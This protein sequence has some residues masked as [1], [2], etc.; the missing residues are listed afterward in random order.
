MATMESALTLSLTVFSSHR[1]SNTL[2]SSPKPPNSVKLH[3]PSL[4]YTNLIFPSSSKPSPFS[5]STTAL[6]FK[7]CS[8]L[9]EAPSTTETEENKTE[10]S[11]TQSTN[12]KTKLYVYNLPWSLSSSDIKD[13]FA[14]CGTVTDVEII[15]SP[16]GK[17]R[18][19]CFV[20]MA[21][22]DEAMDAV[23][24]FHSQE[25]SGRIIQVEFAKRFKKPSPPRPPGPPPG[26]TRNVIYVSNLAWKARSSHF[27]D[28][29][30]EN[31]KTPVSA[32]VVFDSASGR[33]AGYGF[34][35]FLTKEDA[36]AAIS[37]LDGKEL[38]GRPL[39]LKW[40]EKKVNEAGSE[41]NEGND[42]LKDDA[43]AQVQDDSDAQPEDIAGEAQLEE[44]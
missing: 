33:S 28:F 23:N 4:H 25:I 5:T 8:A 10:Q 1:F 12:A 42:Q 16:G 2:P 41:N 14:Q 7:V 17:S 3:P 36:D 34:A 32:R 40:S 29:V 35:S 9:Q 20:T 13:L 31:F 44:T 26:E 27:R 43:D 38:M 19:F 30:T 18:G 15:K 39:R 37:A 6:C 21:T 24:K 22:G 11:Q